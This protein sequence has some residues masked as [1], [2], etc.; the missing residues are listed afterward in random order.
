MV[1]IKVD[2]F[3]GPL[4]LLL[5]LIDREQLDIA[6]LS[7]AEVADQYWAEID[8][9]QEFDADTLSDF[10][11]VGS[12]L[13]Y[14]KSC[15]LIPSAQPASGELRDQIEEAAG[16][17]T[18]LLEEHKRFKDAV[19]LFRQLEE[20]GRRTYSRVS[21]V[22]GVLLPPGLEGV[23]L[24]SL[25]GTVKEAL[26]RKPAEPEE[27]VLHIEP[28]TVHEKISEISMAL[29]ASKGRLGFRPLLDRCQT[30]TEIVVLFLA[31][32]ELIKSGELWAEQERPFGDIV[33]V[34][35]SAEPV[36]VE[37]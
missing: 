17:L 1:Q 6:V 20:D 36:A 5:D 3:D 28:V 15:A 25:L 21:P 18:Q 34:E 16:Q 30:R 7:L 14:I 19:D 27:A 10:I 26:A 23:T 33:L 37:A 2:G 11:A 35:G 29:S 12:K 8:G 9:A 22:Q 32:L 24:D 4:D 13:L 31:V